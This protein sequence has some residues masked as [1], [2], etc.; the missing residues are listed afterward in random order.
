MDKTDHEITCSQKEIKKIRLIARSR[1]AGIWRT[2]RAKVILGALEGKTIDRL[3][4]DVR[5]PPETIK[6][7][8]KNFASNGLKFF[9]KPDRNPTRREAAVE[10]MLA[11][12]EQPAHPRS[13]Q[14]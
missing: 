2:K 13:K 12:L 11:F 4:L 6:K 7:R 5:V 8:L 10:K 1:T 14:E 9:E 3:V